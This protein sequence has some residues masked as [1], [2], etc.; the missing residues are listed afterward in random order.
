MTTF[1]EVF[2]ESFEHHTW[3]DG[4]V[5]ALLPRILSDKG[6]GTFGLERLPL[7]RDEASLRAAVRAL[8]FALEQLDG[9][10]GPRVKVPFAAVRH[11]YNCLVTLEN[12]LRGGLRPAVFAPRLETALGDSTRIL[13]IVPELYERLPHVESVIVR[14]VSDGYG[15]AVSVLKDWQR[16]AEPDHRMTVLESQLVVT[17]TVGRLNE[18]LEAGVQKVQRIRVAR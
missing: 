4:I 17:Y 15:H 7:L 2:V 6:F 14:A 16:D 1:A 3:L 5:R 18:A 9:M 8:D 13:G 11:T 10:R 12:V